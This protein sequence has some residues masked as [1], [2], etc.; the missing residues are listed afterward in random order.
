LRPAELKKLCEEMVEFRLA[1][2]CCCL[3][4]SFVA[5]C[6]A[7]EEPKETSSANDAKSLL[8]L[9]IFC[10]VDHVDGRIQITA[11]GTKDF[12]M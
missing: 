4:N 6:Q 7:I 1:I 8:G 5:V 11:I 12:G 3:R 2:D 10:G 9:D